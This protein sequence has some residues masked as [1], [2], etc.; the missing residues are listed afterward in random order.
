MET[1]SSD[2][3][4]ADT[5]ELGVLA[6]SAEAGEAHRS[7]ATI[8]QPPCVKRVLCTGIIAFQLHQLVFVAYLSKALSCRVGR[9][10]EG[11]PY[12][13]V[14]MLV[15]GVYAWAIGA[16]ELRR[17][18]PGTESRAKR[19]CLLAGMVLGI[20]TVASVVSTGLALV[21]GYILSLG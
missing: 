19:G 6:E 20:I 10:T 13:V 17:M 14:T 3:H 2:T 4:D 18:K 15:L 12:I 8:A 7:R 9:V 5:D 16:G 1:T 11:V 21:T